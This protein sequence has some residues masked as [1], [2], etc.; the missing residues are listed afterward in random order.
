M[1]GPPGG[2]KSSLLQLLAGLLDPSGVQISGEVTYNGE[3]LDS[4]LPEHTVA[5]VPQVIISH[6]TGECVMYCIKTSSIGLTARSSK[7]LHEADGLNVQFCN[8]T[9][10]RDS[11]DDADC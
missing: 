2:G 5:Y 9:G 8:M 10:H 7:F 3:S 1:M 11:L 4:F 6:H